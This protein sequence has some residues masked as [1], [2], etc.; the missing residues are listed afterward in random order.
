[1]SGGVNCACVAFSVRVVIARDGVAQDVVKTDISVVTP[2]PSHDYSKMVAEKRGYMPWMGAEPNSTKRR[3][4]LS[5][6][7]KDAVGSRRAAWCADKEQEERTKAYEQQAADAMECA[8]KLEA[9]LQRIY[10][11]TLA[12]MDEN[13]IPSAS[14]GEPKMFYYEMK[15][16]YYRFLAECATGD[17]KSKASDD[18]CVAY[19]EATKGQ[20]TVEVPQVVYIDRAVDVSMVSQRQTPMIQKVLKTVEI[21]QVQYIGKIGEA[22]VVRQGQ[23]PTIQAVQKTVEVPQVQFPD[24]V[25]GVLV[26]MQRQVPVPQTT[27]EIIEV[28]QLLPPEQILERVVEETDVPVPRV[29]RESSKLRR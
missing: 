18:V 15:G 19:A 16:D 1:M 27:E 7:H 26:V 20:K 3:D 21:P 6:A 9:E 10:A 14:T 5:V 2:I 17:A 12:L 28:S 25:V 23:A 24:R 8:V 4:P 29:R 22:S 13:L 11:G